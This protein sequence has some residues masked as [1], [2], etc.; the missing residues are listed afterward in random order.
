MGSRRR[1]DRPADGDDDGPLDG[2]R[3]GQLAHVM[4]AELLRDGVRGV[5]FELVASRV[6]RHALLERPLVY[7]AAAQAELVTSVCAWFRWFVLDRTW[8]FVGA[9]VA[10]PGCRFDLVFDHGRLG[11]LVDELKTGRLSGI[12]E[13]DASGQLARLLAG[14]R[15]RYGAR[16]YAL[17]VLQLSAASRSFVIYAD[18]RREALAWV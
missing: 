3:C 9:E 13:G 5:D 16:F 11:V 8:A 10:A 4:I 6:A 1:A 15:S 7:R 17:R 2:R 14:A 18:G 12:G